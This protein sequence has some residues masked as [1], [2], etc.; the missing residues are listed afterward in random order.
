MGHSYLDILHDG[1]II[2]VRHRDQGAR[3][4]YPERTNEGVYKIYES[5]S[6]RA[7]ENYD[8]L[9]KMEIFLE[10]AIQRQSAYHF[11]FHPSDPRPLFENEFKRTLRLLQSE[12]ES[13]ALWVT[14][15]SD[16]AAYCEARARLNLKVKERSGDRMT[17]LVESTLNTEKYGL[18]DVTLVIPATSLPQRIL[19]ESVGTVRELKPAKDYAIR[20]GGLTFDLPATNQTVRL[21]F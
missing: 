21:V 11:W 18:P 13:G 4:S 12:R 14:T 15:M 19:L 10:R 3:L 5:M 17:L 20:N 8:L 2:A 9:D 7:P 1:G 16:L 6:L